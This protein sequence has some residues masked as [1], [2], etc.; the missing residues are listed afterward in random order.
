MFSLSSCSS[1]LSES[2]AMK[3]IPD[4][5][6]AELEKRIDS[7]SGVM[8]SFQTK[9]LISFASRLSQQHQRGSSSIPHAFTLET[10]AAIKSL[11]DITHI[12]VLT[13]N[14]TIIIVVIV[15]FLGIASSNRCFRLTLVKPRTT[16]H[17]NALLKRTFKVYLIIN[18]K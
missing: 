6:N 16:I 15:S 2:K 8:S 11:K 18:N 4:S 7:L 5:S 9:I 1:S 3:L 17:D 13:G 12:I 10:L 14:V